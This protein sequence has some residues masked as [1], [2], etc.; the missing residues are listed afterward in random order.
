MLAQLEQKSFAR[1]YLN[2][3]TTVLSTIDSEAIDQAIEL[4]C[5]A[6][7][8]G[9]Q[10]IT[11]GN[12]G[13]AVTALHF[14]TDWN[15][16]LYLKGGRPFRGRTLVDNMGLVM[17]YANDM[18]FE[19][20]FVEQLKNIVTKGDLII[21]ISGSGNSENVIRAVTYANS[22]GCHSIG[23]CGFSGGRLKDV[24]QHLVWARVDDMQLCEDVH[25]IFGHIVMQALCLTAE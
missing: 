24:A 18:G 3:L 23:L 9:N 4:I 8:S 16:S 12:G 25:A 2:R 17:A 11:L 15:K 5:N 21:A 20:V 10:I 1:H 22:V 6:W 19:N 7:K 13:S 14:I